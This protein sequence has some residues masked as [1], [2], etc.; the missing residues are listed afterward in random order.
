MLS[1]GPI[2]RRSSSSLRALASAPT[3]AWQRVRAACL[4]LVGLPISAVLLRLAASSRGGVGVSLVYHRVGDPPGDP[5]RELVPAM[6]I[7]L[8]AAQVQ[9]LRRRY[10]VVAASELLSAV[11]GRRRGDAFPVAITFDDDLQ[12]HADVAAPI[13]SAAGV[14]GTF[15]LCGASL[16]A[17]HAFWWERLQAAVDEGLDLQPLGF[18]ARRRSAIHE[19]GRSIEALAPAERRGVERRLGEITGPDSPDAGLRAEAVGR[20]LAAGCEVGFHTRRHDAL[21]P[22]T[23]AELADAFED[24]RGELED[25]VGNRL[26]VISYPHGQA[27]FRVALAART[28]GFT[29]GFTGSQDV[30]R[31]DSEPLLLGR[32]SPSYR[33]VGEFAFDLAWALWRSARQR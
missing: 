8:F 28:A 6:G 26:T 9:H 25:V 14:T 15:F 33:S 19:L 24:G 21:P 27:D 17:P 29:T 5:R 32:L 10:R 2:W 30:V 1:A 7:R 11:R 12:A 4:R 31:P 13:L 20:L 23:D 16:R 22:L 3:R 18:D